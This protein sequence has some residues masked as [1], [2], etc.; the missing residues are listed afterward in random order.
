[1]GVTILL[2][3]QVT[4]RAGRATA[5]TPLV[6]TAGEPGRGLPWSI[7]RHWTFDREYAAVEIRDDEEERG[8][9]GSHCVL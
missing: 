3:E 2:G 5:D 6:V 7:V 4:I 8:L 9:A 1:V